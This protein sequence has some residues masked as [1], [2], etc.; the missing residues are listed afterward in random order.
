M[1]ANADLDYYA[2]YSDRVHAVTRADIARYLDTY[3][4]GKPFVLG[5]LESPA[6]AKTIESGAPREGRRHHEGGC[7]MNRS[8]ILLLPVLTL[9]ACAAPPPAPVVAPPPPVAVTPPPP[10]APPADPA[11]ITE[12]D[13]TVA[14]SR[15]MQIVVKRAPGAEF[16]AAE[17]RIRGGVRNWTKD[18]A[19][20]EQVALEVAT[21]GGTQSLAKEPFS[22]KL[23]SLGASVEGGADN[24]CSSITVKAPLTSWDELFPVFVE[25]FLAPALPA[26]EFDIVKQRELSARR[27]EMEDGD[28]RLWLLARRSVFAGHPYANRPVGS[29]E[30]LEAMK[31][32]DLAPQLAMLRDTNRLVLVVVGDVD[33]GYVI[34]K[35]KA[36]FASVPRGSYTETPIPPL[37]LDGWRVTGDAFKL[38][39][40][41]IESFFAG[42]T[43]SDPD[44]APMWL[45]MNLLRD[46]LFDEVRT[47]RNL[48]YAPI[49]RFRLNQSAPFGMLYVTAVDPNATMRVMFDEARRLQGEL[50]PAK[51]LEAAKAMF[52]SGYLQRHETVDGQ[53]SALADAVVLGGDWHLASLLLDRV[54]A[55]TPEALQGAARKWF[56]NVQTAIVGDPTK[57]DPKI[58]GGP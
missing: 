16:V 14:F 48:S 3:V 30:T 2:T 8:A 24:D 17:L 56:T 55:A 15:G 13:V 47:K 57:L 35:A 19:G 28:G 49:A 29:V 53:A 10:P 34:D 27:H 31:A 45:E 21:S 25:T 4:L 7:A 44:F 36:G 41:Y 22:R 52:L 18:N 1:W 5:A 43:W 11:P 39:T 46:R 50:I 40:N 6:L 26:S 9:A 38:P 37:H 58:V 54:R 51:E 20:I 32:G 23:A 42:P 12:G 33:A